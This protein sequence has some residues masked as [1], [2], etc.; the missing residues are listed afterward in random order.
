MTPLRASRRFAPQGF[1]AI[2]LTVVVAI[3]GIVMAIAIPA[4]NTMILNAKIKGVAESIQ[5][6]LRQARSEAIKRN[7]PMRFQLVTN[8]DNTCTL[9]TQ[10]TFWVVSQYVIS[11]TRG[12]V[13]GA[14]DALPA[15]PENLTPPGDQEEPCPTGAATS[16]AAQPWIAVKS[17]S[18]AVTG[19]QVTGAPAMSSAFIVTFG[20]LGQILDNLEGAKPTA[21]PVYTLDIQAASTAQS[22]LQYRVQINTSGGIKLCNPNATDTM[23]CPTS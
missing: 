22:A 9:T 18:L 7:A 11:G 1:S 5:A 3:I 16:C 4:F 2:E 20:P 12:V 19:V 15:M 23:A 13:S 14:C 8:L 6:G 21:S 10:S 17:D